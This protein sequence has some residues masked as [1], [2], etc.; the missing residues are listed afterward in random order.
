MSIATPPVIECLFLNGMIHYFVI[1]FKC[2]FEQSFFFCL[3]YNINVFSGRLYGI[4]WNRPRSRTLFVNQ[5][6]VYLY[7]ESYRSDIRTFSFRANCS[8]VSRR[9]DALLLRMSLSV[10]RGIP[11]KI[12]TCRMDRFLSDI[13]LS[14][15][16][17]I[18]VF[19][20]IYFGKIPVLLI[21]EVELYGRS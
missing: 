5:A 17:F 20:L 10:D 9:G 14:S 2:F 7:G 15:N 16:I 13:I 3:T 11:V 21:C 18:L 8:R 4:F 12:E 6:T 19:F 1:H